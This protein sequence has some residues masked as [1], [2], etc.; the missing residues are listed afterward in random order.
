VL[1]IGGGLGGL[2]LAQGLRRAGV[3]VTVFERDADANA[4]RQGRRININGTGAAALHACLPP[5]LWRALVATAGDPGETFAFLNEQLDEL[6]L[7]DREKFMEHGGTAEYGNHAVSR[8][9]LRHLLLAGLGDTVQFDKKFLRYERNPD[10][11]VTA[12]FAD[13][14]SATGNVLIGADGV[15]SG[16]ASQYLPNLRRVS[17][18]TVSLAGMIWLTEETRTWL[19]HLTTAGMN[20]LWPPHHAMFTAVFRRRA[21]IADTL[22]ETGADLVADGIEPALIAEESADRDHVLWAIMGHHEAFPPDVTDLAP[23]QIRAVA[24]AASEGWHPG[25]RRMIEE[26][27]P[28]L[29]NAIDLKA[30]EPIGAWESTTITVLGDAI[31]NMP[32]TGGVGGNMALR[33]AA[34]LAHAL[35][36]VDSGEQELTTAIAAY[37]AEMRTHGFGAVQESVRMAKVT[38]DRNRTEPPI[39]MFTGR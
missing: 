24:L 15:H 7:L 33:D 17:T 16:V 8:V 5:G 13:G 28:D 29:F 6:L 36:E 14:T 12:F 19:P 26:S 4:R 18:G 9:T 34:A 39:P 22:R 11:T 10:G 27:D 37:E 35:A 3:G 38:A 23:T 30:T 20:V 32:P 21:G 31:H 2:C 1:V 25:I